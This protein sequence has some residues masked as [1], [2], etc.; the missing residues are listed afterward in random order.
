MG[1]AINNNKTGKYMGKNNIQMVN[2]NKSSYSES[3]NNNNIIN[4]KNQENFNSK[5]LS[6][7]SYGSYCLSFILISMFTGIIGSIAG[8]L[9]GGGS[10]FS[11]IDKTHGLNHAKIGAII[12]IMMPSA[13]VLLNH[14]CQ[15]INKPTTTNIKEKIANCFPQKI[16]MR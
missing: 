16:I 4:N 11:P 13:I 14:V 8:E 2:L 3:S 10:L 12:G 6:L 1:F 7:L 9:M 15:L 5:L